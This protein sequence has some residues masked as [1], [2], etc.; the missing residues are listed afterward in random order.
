MYV[1]SL[2]SH[3]TAKKR[4]GDVAEVRS[5]YTF[6]DGLFEER[7]GDLGVIRMRDIDE[8]NHL[9]PEALVRVRM[10]QLPDRHL[11]Q[12]GDVLFSSRGTSYSATVVTRGLGRAALSAPMLLIRPNGE[13]LDPAY[14]QWFIN[15]P[16]TQS[17]LSS[18]AAG[19][20][21]KMV[22][23]AELEKLPIALPP[24]EAQ[25]KIAELGRLAQEEARLSFELL[26]QRRRL[27]ERILMLYVEGQTN[28]ERRTDTMS[29]GSRN[30]RFVQ[31]NPNGGWDNKKAGASRAASHHD[32]KQEAIDVAR[33]MSRR[34]G[35]ELKIKN[36]DRKIA[37][38]DSHGHDPRN[39]KG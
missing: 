3:C 15:N 19:S 23:K 30:I 11:V 6:R 39:I 25:R 1:H 5:G 36:A 31:P 17:Q 33:D 37:Q 14:L 28:K 13:V 21:V 27:M 29:K 12:R 24:I 7:D 2:K 20:A 32:T 18:R 10:P 38:S 35:S 16:D 22:S 34:E 26:Q 9:H 8:A 4:L